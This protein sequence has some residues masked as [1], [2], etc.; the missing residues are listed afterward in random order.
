MKRAFLAAFLLAAGPTYAACTC[1]CVNGEVQPLCTSSLDLPPICAPR[2]CPLTPPAIQPIERP[3]LPPLG[4]SSC[5]QQQVLNPSTGR[6][7]WRTIC[8]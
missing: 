6:Y 4:T 3:T 2:I 7:E 1:Q 8:R 5:S